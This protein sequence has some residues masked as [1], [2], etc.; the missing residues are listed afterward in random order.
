MKAKDILQIQPLR[1]ELRPSGGI[2]NGLVN[3]MYE[4]TTGFWRR[5]TTQF[6][7]R[8]MTRTG[9]LW[10]WIDE[11]T[12]Y[13]HELSRVIDGHIQELAGGNVIHVEGPELIETEKEN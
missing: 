6:R 4:E 5:K 1:I 11:P 7:R 12:K 13:Q 3:V 2:D 9:I 10:T 8:A